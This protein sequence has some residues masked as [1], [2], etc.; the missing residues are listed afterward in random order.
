MATT[1]VINVDLADVWSTTDRKGR[2]LLR[3]VAWGDEVEVV[4]KTSTHIELRLTYFQEAEDGS[5][6]PK[7]S[8]GYI[9]PSKSSGI[10]TDDAII[11]KSK[12][13][14]L[15][16]NFVDVQ[17]GDGSVIET[18]KGKVILVDGGDNQL[19]ARYLAGRF[20]GTSAAKPQRIEC[21]LVTHGDADHFQGLP[22]IFKSEK[23]KDKRKRLFIQP[24]RVYHNGI[25]KRPGKMN[26][27]S[28]PDEKLLGKTK[29]V[30]DV[31]YL[32]G[33]EDDLLG[34]DQSEMNLPFKSWRAAL[35]VYNKRS[36]LQFRRLQFQDD[37]AF[38]FLSGEQIKVQVL[39]PL[40]ETIDGKPA[41]RFLGDPPKGP[42]VGHESLE[43]SD[44]EST[45]Y[46]ASHTINGHSIV[47]KMTYGQISYLFSGDLNDE[48]G[49]FL[50]QKHNSGDLNLNADVFK[51]PHHG[52]ADFSGAFIQAVAPIVSV[53]SS[54][55]ESARK[56][57][58]H[59]RATLMGALGKYSRVPEPLIFVTELVAFFTLEG[60]SK[61]S[62]PKKKNAKAF[63]A[64]SRTAYGMVKT[65]T[66]GERLLVYT[67]SG[68]IKMKE[69]Y[70]YQVDSAGK[71]TPSPV[72]RA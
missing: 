19:F 44:L 12:N 3:T 68:N 64:F 25:V 28:V 66:D 55:D 70:A 53:V 50:T 47:F 4:K 21:M 65:R 71:L 23:H 11:P 9:A 57:Y 69:A 1:H 16:V 15:K 31:L 24:E 49:R 45:G 52:S 35:E 22:E 61:H 56:E 6:L 58:I 54:G 63:F 37:D 29:K 5:I 17:Q 8:T 59:P 38:D 67:D 60:W 20:R 33:L 7:T 2:K 46:S 72:A 26:N 40:V 27:K 30:D 34:V 62:P 51:V 42:R 13:K 48:A 10:K 43:P 36:P 14:V 41:L 32:V 39:G 18:P